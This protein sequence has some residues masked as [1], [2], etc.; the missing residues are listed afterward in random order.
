MKRKIS[1]L[2]MAGVLSSRGVLAG[3]A[4]SNFTGQEMVVTA[5]KTVNMRKDIPNAVIVINQ[6]EIKASTAL[7]VG[8]LLANRS[9][10]DLGSYGNY[11]GAVEEIHMRGMNADGTQVFVNGVRMNSISLGSADVAKI[12]LSNIERIEIVKGSGSLLYGSGASGGVINIFTREPVKDKTDFSLTSE[13]GTQGTYGIALSHG[14][15]ITDKLAYLMTL[16]KKVTDG[17]RDNSDLD[18]KNASIKFAYHNSDSFNAS[19]SGDFVDREYGMPG[20]Q[21]PAGTVP[22][23]DL[24]G[25]AYYNNESASLLNRH[26]DRDGHVVMHIDGKASG[27]LHYNFQTDYSYSRS[28]N[29]Q[30]DTSGYYSSKTWVTNQVKTAEGNLTFKPFGGFE[31]LAG[32]EFRHYDYE[33]RQAPMDFNF[34]PEF[35]ERHDLHSSALYT[36][37]QYRPAQYLKLQSGIRREENSMFGTKNVFRY[38]AVVNLSENTAIKFNCGSHFK[39]P[40][41]N[42]LFWPDDGWTKGNLSLSPEKGWH[43]D[44]TIEQELGDKGLF[45]AG[46][47]HWNIKDKIAW[48]P[49]HAQQNSYGYDYWVPTN[50]DTYKADG[51][52][53]SVRA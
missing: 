8:E 47:F 49:D 28:Y 37:V 31:I 29:Y 23:Y 24:S 6:T 34:N 5:T 15:A 9:G 52:E 38:G 22:Y 1:L 33:N 4:I 14:K 46:Y 17:F 26:E 43:T 10:I 36:E 25:V 44:V 11:G 51:L 32:C 41:M 27:K 50:L 20:V 19:L 53:L 35:D 16:G 48:A 18:D 42:D 3:E 40:T 45:T 7:S 12:P 2:V 13:Y 30:R 39:A 21:P